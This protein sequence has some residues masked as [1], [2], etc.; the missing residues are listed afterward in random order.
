MDTRRQ[1]GQDDLLPP[2]P[3]IDA[4]VQLRVVSTDVFVMQKGNRQVPLA[5]ISGEKG[6]KTT[7]QINMLMDAANKA[8][9][10]EMKKIWHRKIRQLLVRE[11]VE[12]KSA[13]K[14][15]IRKKL[16]GPPVPRYL[17]RKKGD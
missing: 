14:S 12:K 1:E 2:L 7:Q 8:Q 5:Y 16:D 3:C 17:G 4:R 15:W 11:L 6:M 9:D 10:V 13:D